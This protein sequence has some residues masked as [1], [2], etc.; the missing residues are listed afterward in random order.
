[1]Q[2]DE[3]DSV[4][5]LAALFL[6]HLDKVSGIRKDSWSMELSRMPESTTL[7]PWHRLDV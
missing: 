2:S 1:M 4:R 3:A 7:K 6:Y 5:S